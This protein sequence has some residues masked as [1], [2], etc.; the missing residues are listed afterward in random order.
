MLG[1]SRR[2]TDPQRKA[3]LRRTFL[4][5]LVAGRK[6]GEEMWTHI[7]IP[8]QG[9][10]RSLPCVITRNSIKVAKHIQI[11]TLV[12]R[13]IQAK[14]A[15]NRQRRSLLSRS[16]FHWIFRSGVPTLPSRQRHFVPRSSADCSYQSYRLLLRPLTTAKA[17][18]SAQQPSR[19]FLSN[20]KACASSR[21]TA[22]DCRL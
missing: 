13:S 22:K 19:L 7:C 21:T 12:G 11:R 5:C 4:S 17:S 18:N 6:V 10:D 9:S 1:W 8:S 16:V 2:G 3:S 14:A 20:S 15:S